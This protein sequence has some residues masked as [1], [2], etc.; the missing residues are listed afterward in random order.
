MKGTQRRRYWIDRKIQGPFLLKMGS[1]WTGGLLLL[2]LLLYYFADEE[3]GRS[4]Y[5]VHLRLR[6][7]WQI[8]L[9]AV[10]LSGGISFLITIGVT[11]LVAVRESHRLGGPI[12]KFTKLFRELESGS[13][14]TDFRFR[15]G[16]LLIKMGESYR[17][18]LE[19]NRERIR[20]M[21]TLGR[22]AE[23]NLEILRENVLPGALPSEERKLLDDSLRHV[24][25]LRHI[26]GSFHL[27]TR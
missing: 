23:A 9:P 27:E 20:E 13:F 22:Q 5:S 21:Q 17:A 2:C 19:A 3:L 25:Q 1:V 24:S 10:V 8:L 15:K 7:T 18:A 26:L 4:F 14:E 16:D 6:N 12:Y 11:I